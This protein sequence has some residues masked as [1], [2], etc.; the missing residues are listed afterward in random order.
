M[1]G[2]TAL[3]INCHVIYFVTTH[4]DVL[5]VDLRENVLFS[6]FSYFTICLF[7]LPPPL[8]SV[9]LLHRSPADLN[10]S[11]AVSNRQNQ[12]TRGGSFFLSLLDSQRKWQISSMKVKR[13]W[14]TPWMRSELRHVFIG[15]LKDA[16]KSIKIV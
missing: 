4:L 3:Y 12:V 15:C 13:S 14:K 9:G 2:Y 6:I 11:P 16:V 8:Y 5:I 1:V 7:C 10:R